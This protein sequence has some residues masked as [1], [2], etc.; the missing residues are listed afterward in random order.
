MSEPL[1]AEAAVTRGNQIVAFL[2]DPDIRG[3]LEDLKEQNYIEFTNAKSS[4]QRVTTWAKAQVL[5]DF[6]TALAAIVSAGERGA[7][8]IKSAEKRD[9]RK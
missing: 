7:A 4:D 2:K 8:Q 9:L 6:A 5:Q 3:A 1:S